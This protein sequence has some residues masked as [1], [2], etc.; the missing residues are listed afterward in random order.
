MAWRRPMR[1]SSATRSAVTTP[2]IAVAAFSA[3]VRFRSSKES[4]F[5]SAPTLAVPTAC[6]ACTLRRGIVAVTLPASTSVWG[7]V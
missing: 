2:T 4:S 1:L 7:A 5:A 6:Q 3:T